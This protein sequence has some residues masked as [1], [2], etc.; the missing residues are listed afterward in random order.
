[1]KLFA[2]KGPETDWIAAPTEDDARVILKRHYGISDDD[3]AG[4]YEVIEEVDPLTVQVYPDDWDYDNDP[5]DLPT[6]AEYM[7]KPGLVC[8]TCQ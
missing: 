1:M 5:E 3:I 8:S 6:A 4:S 2:F 7:A